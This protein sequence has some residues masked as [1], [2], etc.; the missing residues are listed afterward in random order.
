MV[1]EEVQTSF[2]EIFLQI[3]NSSSHQAKDPNNPD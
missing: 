3:L 2:D 1:V